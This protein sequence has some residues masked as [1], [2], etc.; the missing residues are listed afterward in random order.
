[1]RSITLTVALLLTL[2]ALPAEAA[3]RPEPG[4]PNVSLT[5]DPSTVSLTIH[6][7]GGLPIEIID[8]D[9][10]GK[11]MPDFGLSIRVRDADGTL[12]QS[13]PSAEGWWTP[14][15]MVSTLYPANKP[16]LRTLRA[17]ERIDVSIAPSQLLTG[18]PGPRPTSGTCAFQV[19]AIVST[20]PSYMLSSSPGPMGQLSGWVKAPCADLFTPA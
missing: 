2:F 14:S 15:A 13:Q 16:P 17:R 19:H 8:E 9:F 18:F 5:V 3:R 12:L 11:S 20:W 7:F 1:M 10:D 6:N 4:W